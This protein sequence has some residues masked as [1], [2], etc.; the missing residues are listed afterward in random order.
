MSVTA[1][2]G[3]YRAGSPPT[4]GFGSGEPCQCTTE[5]QA[6][7]PQEGRRVAKATLVQARAAEGFQIVLAVGIQLPR[8]LVCDP[9][10]RYVGLRAAQLLQRSGC[11]LGL[12]G[13]AGGHR[14]Y[15]VGAGEIAALTDRLAR[16]G[17]SLLV[18]SSDKL[19]IG[20]DSVI[21]R[22]RRVARAQSNGTL[23]G[24]MGFLPT[25]TVGQCEA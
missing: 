25:P 9:G 8:Q 19:R 16:Q 15:P 10:Q 1:M 14:Q 24:F 5:R 13:H 22:G 18:V 17:D 11:D 3:L 4:S 2:P 7:D 20:G 21:N 12:P 23:R 6:P